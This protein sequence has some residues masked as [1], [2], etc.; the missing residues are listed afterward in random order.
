MLDLFFCRRDR[1]PVDLG[2]RPDPKW[3]DEEGFL[4]FV[5]GHLA[6][7]LR[8]GCYTPSPGDSLTRWGCI[9]I[10]G[11][12][13]HKNGVEDVDA[14]CEDMLSRCDGPVYLEQSKSG[15]G[16]HL[17]FFFEEAVP[18][19]DVRRQLLIV[20]GG[21]ECEVFPKTT[22]LREEGFGG[23]VWL[24]FF[25]RE[26]DRGL[27]S[28]ETGEVIGWGD[29]VE[30]YPLERVSK[31]EVAPRQGSTGA[32]K[33]AIVERLERSRE[34]VTAERAGEMLEFVDSD[35]PRQQW[36]SLLCVLHD[37][38]EEGPNAAEG[39]AREWSE[40]GDL[41]NA[42]H[43]EKDWRS[44]RGR[45]LG[46]GSVA[47]LGSLIW[48]ARDGGWKGQ[49][50]DVDGEGQV[51]IA[52]GQETTIARDVLRRLDES[53][54]GEIRMICGRICRYEEGVGIWHAVDKV[55]IVN[56]ALEYQGRET[57]A[58]LANVSNPKANGIFKSVVSWVRGRGLVEEAGWGLTFRNGFL[59]SDRGLVPVHRRQ[60]SLRYV[61]VDFDVG[62]V[63]S[64]LW[65]SFL[66][67]AFGNVE[68]GGERV[69]AL[70]QFVGACLVGKAS[71]F[72]RA[73]L[74]Y[75]V[76]GSGKST[77]VD[78]VSV[79]F[80]SD[81]S[82][83][84]PQDF[85]LHEARAGLAGKKLNVETD[86]PGGRFLDTGAF[87]KLV[88]GEKTRAR[89][90]YK[91]AFDLVPQCGF[92]FASNGLPSSEDTSDGFFRRWLIIGF[93]NPLEHEDRDPGFRDRLTQS[94]LESGWLYAWA[95]RGWLDLKS[96]GYYTLPPSHVQIVEGWREANDPIYE[97][98][99]GSCSPVRDVDSE[100]GDWITTT[101]AWQHYRKW[102]ARCGVKV[103]GPKTFSQKLK[104][105]GVLQRR[106][107]RGT[108][109]CLKIL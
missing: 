84:A 66:D 44:I 72:C 96:Q 78:A 93:E 99:S 90:L 22:V 108:E 77:F 92:L 71:E 7:E 48:H 46:D 50:R 68:D 95:W 74:L 37:F 86:M 61:D 9:D 35:L 63:E 40:R 94:V 73:C 8:I 105:L 10:D 103:Y 54:G 23:L 49:V 70:Q 19:A 6:G 65:A 98:L 16:W 4:S 42:R 82:H 41:W 27:V 29:S 59:D 83:V 53:G 51:I 76:G 91:E 1:V 39:V 106:T 75:G 38:V 60:F 109:N 32:G 18:A 43:F 80:G 58:G 55:E 5:N 34:K 11:G 88:D 104:T 45:F 64:P 85:R 56:M 15:E 69:R 13:A 81:V 25:G 57:G 31:R 102:A 28:V 24:P 97:W 79:M 14:T 21:W 30:Y 20:D 36:F 12:E 17:W 26:E 89:N 87:K 67:R 47:G 52:N 101:D 2:W 100:S 33:S 107:K 62:A 3:C